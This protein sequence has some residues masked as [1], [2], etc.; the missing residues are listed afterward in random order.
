MRSP[1]CRALHGYRSYEYIAKNNNNKQT[2]KKNIQRQKRTIKEKLLPLLFL[3]MITRRNY[4]H[5]HTHTQAAKL[6]IN[7]DF[8]YT[9]YFTDTGRFWFLIVACCMAGGFW[10][11]CSKKI[12]Q[13]GQNR[14]RASTRP[15]VVVR[16]RGQRL[17]SQ[18]C[19]RR[20]RF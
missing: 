3:S 16:A 20:H 5:I 1:L 17:H 7:E 11:C 4:T 6:Y 18:P 9:A 19:R 8:R 13:S 2:E 12:L 10:Q 15:A 14:N